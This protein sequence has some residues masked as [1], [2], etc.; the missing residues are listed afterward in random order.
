MWHGHAAQLLMH[1]VQRN[2]FILVVFEVRCEDARGGGCEEA[3]VGVMHL[4]S[5]VDVD[6]VVV[7]VR[8]SGRI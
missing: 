2:V 6:L 4:T 1:A 3:E 5:M 7:V 8:A